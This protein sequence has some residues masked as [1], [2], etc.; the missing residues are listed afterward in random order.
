MTKNKPALVRHNIGDNHWYEL[1][2]P[3]GK[4]EYVPGVT[5]AVSAGLAIPF[6]VAANWAA[7]KCAIYTAERRDFLAGLTYDETFAI[8]KAQAQNVTDQ[9]AVKGKTIHAYADQLQTTGEVH[10]QPEHAH[11]A[12][13][14]ELYADCLDR[15]EIEPAASEVPVAHTDLRWAGT[16]DLIARS[17]RAVEW[18]NQNGGNIPPDALGIVDLKTG[19]KVRDKD[20]VQV[21]AYASANLAI[22][23]GHEQPMPAVHWAGIIHVDENRAELQLIRPDRWDDV[24]QVWLRCLAQW[25]AADYKRGWLSQALET[26]EELDWA[27]A[28]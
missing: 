1:R 8:V 27:E 15:W 14:V 12:A 10:L 19:N 11:W 13:H 17:A 25:Q 22:I 5:T 3:D 6:G 26:A 24:Y 7:E 28:S 20:A 2:R 23:D 21:R 4:L 9:A 16:T 18:L